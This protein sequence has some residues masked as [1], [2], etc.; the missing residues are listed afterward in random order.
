MAELRSNRKKELVRKAV[1]M[2]TSKKGDMAILESWEQFFVKKDVPY[3]IFADNG[4]VYLYKNMET[5]LASELQ[6][7]GWNVSSK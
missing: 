3:S 7:L 4:T 6:A 1:F 5:L 2:K